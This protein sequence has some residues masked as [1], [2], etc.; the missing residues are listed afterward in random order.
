MKSIAF[1]VHLILSFAYTSSFG[2]GIHL[3]KHILPAE[4]NGVTISSVLQGRDHYLWLGTSEGL[5]RFEG[6]TY[7]RFIQFDSTDNRISAIYET[8]EGK[9]WIGYS[10]GSIGSFEKGRFKSSVHIANEA[11]TSFSEDSKGRLWVSIYGEGLVAISKTDTIK[12]DQKTGLADNY[13]YKVIENKGKIIAATDRGLSIINVSNLSHIQ[14]ID[15]RHG[16]PDNIVTSLSN[17][18]DGNLW[19]GTES[20]GLARLNDSLQVDYVTKEWQYG[21]VTSVLALADIL[22][23]GTSMNGMVEVSLKDNTV[24]KH[25]DAN[26]NFS[27]RVSDIESDREGNV[28]IASNSNY[29]NSFSRTFTFLGHPESSGPIEVQSILASGNGRLYYSTTDG[30]FYARMDDPARQTRITSVSGVQVISRYED[31]F[32]KIWMG[33]F[34]KGVFRY[35]PSNHSVKNITENDGLINNSVLSIAGV[36]EELWFATLGGVSKCS[37]GRNGDDVRFKNFTSESGL[38]SNY[39]YKAFIDSRHR[40][41]FATDG[42]GVTLF[43]NNAFKNFRIADAGKANVIYSIAED[44]RGTIWMST[45]ANELYTFNGDAFERYEPLNKFNHLT[46]ASITGDVDGNILLIAKEG[47]SVIDVVTGLAYHHSDEMGLSAMDPNLNCYSK[48]GN[49]IWIGSDIGIIK[50]DA[51][52]QSKLKFPVTAIEQMQVYLEPHDTSATKLS[53]DENHISFK[54]VGFWYHDPDEVSYRIKLDGYDTD[55][56]RSKNNFITYPNLPPGDYTFHVQSSATDDFDDVPIISLSFSIAPPFYRRPIFYGGLL[57]CFFIVIFLF[58]RSRER[59]LRTIQKQEKEKMRFQMETLKSQVNP[60][61]LFNSFNTLIGVIEEDQ[62]TAV[63]YVEKLSDFYRDI[64]TNREKDVVPLKKE[65]E[66]VDNYYF[67][68]MK[69]YRNNFRI[70]FNVAD[71]L[72]EWLIP[73]LTLQLLIEN[74]LKHN[75]VSSAQPLTIKIETQEAEVIVSNNLQLK[76]VSEPSTGLGLSNIKTRIKLLTDR[77]VTILKTTE[78]FSVRIPLIKPTS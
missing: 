64:L 77:E 48:K 14:S 4:F 76:M 38:G 61:F 62:Q 26:Q 24:K 51:T 21:R 56:S 28:W 59:R 10:N 16:I 9:I 50:Y 22:L 18:A 57:L 67:L 23:V 13:V 43:E 30:V 55:W 29:I 47:I 2:Q 32:G 54:Y 34:D 5:F 25:L 1:F 78:S 71:D 70:R 12:I 65:L 42:K 31:K 69:R 72:L 36:G 3:R 35:D 15:T 11:V 40:V 33:T 6:T 19:L 60:H 49:D 8:R 41:W 63:A 27:L 7:H 73:P 66:M 39:I 68:Q 37:I 46:I 58:V 53:H 20:F 52:A 45:A 74:A 75:V 44:T 17:D